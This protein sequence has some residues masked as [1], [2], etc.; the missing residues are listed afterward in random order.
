MC[1]QEKETL[2]KITKNTTTKKEINE[3]KHK[4]KSFVVRKTYSTSTT[5][6]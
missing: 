4:K 6:K 3:R 5:T 1:V 2:N